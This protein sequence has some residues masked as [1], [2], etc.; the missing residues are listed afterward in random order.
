MEGWNPESASN[1]PTV[2]G[3]EL[4]LMW[5]NKSMYTYLNTIFETHLKMLRTFVLTQYYIIINLRNVFL[6]L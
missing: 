3:E 4:A 5:Q 6:S 1:M 2:K